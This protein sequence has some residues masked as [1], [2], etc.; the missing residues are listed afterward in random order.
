MYN[1]AGPVILRMRAPHADE[2]IAHAQRARY[3]T[4]TTLD[5]IPMAVRLHEAGVPYSV[6]RIWAFEPHPNSTDE[7]AVRAYARARYDDLRRLRDAARN[8]NIL[9]QINNEQ[10]FRADDLLM[11]A[12]LVECAMQDPDG[13]VGMVFWNGSAGSTQNGFWVSGASNGT[14][15]HASHNQWTAQPAMRLVRAMHDARNA[16]LPSGAYAFLLGVHNYSTYYPLIAVDAGMH[17]KTMRERWNAH[18]AN[19]W[20]A[21]DVFL[22]GDAFVDW[23]L[24]QDH[25]GREVQAIRYALGW[26]ATPS[27]TMRPGPETPIADGALMDCPRIIVTECGAA[28]MFDVIPV[29]LDEFVASAHAFDAQNAA[30]DA[31]A[32]YAYALG[33]GLPA[34]ALRRPENMRLR[35]QHAGPYGYRTQAATWAKQSW[36]PGKS[37]GDVLAYWHKWTWDAVLAQTNVVLGIQPFSLGDTGGWETFNLT[38]DTDYLS[39]MEGW[40]VEIPEHW[41]AADGTPPIDEYREVVAELRGMGGA[42]TLR[43][44]ADPGTQS[45][46]VGAIADGDTIGVKPPVEGE[47]AGNGSR[48]VPVRLAGGVRGYA[49]AHHL[50]LPPDMVD[51]PEEPEEPAPE[52]EPEPTP[53][54]IR[55]A[56]KAQVIDILNEAIERVKAL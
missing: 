40:Q 7:S 17:R 34:H 32:A 24:P 56:V 45:E 19:G 44:R 15:Y 20:E 31:R 11:Y 46:V 10:G 5:D 42:A 13:P 26:I 6:A 35:A 2:V 27:G 37:P 50:V 29:H 3:V 23:R 54:E 36:F 28:D 39:T 8:A 22:L 51:P 14:Q 9:F 49:Y 52:P 1:P 21:H 41:L 53:E 12:H 47:N 33:L 55:A 30:D 25:I 43:V 38:G 4:T 48:W 18:Y 16:R